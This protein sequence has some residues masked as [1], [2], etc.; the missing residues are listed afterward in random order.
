[1]F[2]PGEII[3]PPI[4]TANQNNYSPATVQLADTL[5]LSSDASRNI[6]GLVAD[7]GLL[8]STPQ[9][10]ELTLFNVGVQDIVLKNQDAAST[11]A[12]RFAL[13]AD[14]TMSPNAGV[15]LWYDATSSR[16][17]VRAS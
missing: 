9:S 14:I 5:R 6:T 8:P 2:R 1:M 16:W 17:R 4:I 3:T 12:Y 11:A 7:V 13:V 15:I 10:R